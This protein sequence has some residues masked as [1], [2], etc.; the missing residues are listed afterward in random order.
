M[1][2]RT[3]ITIR[4]LPGR[5]LE[6]RYTHA[7]TPDG[8]ALALVAPPHPL[9]GGSIGNPVVRAIENAYAQSGIATLAFN[10]RGIGASTG[11]PSDDMA[12]ALAEYIAAAEALPQ[13]ALYALS[14]YSFGAIAA[15]Q[16]AVALGV[17]RVL[18]VAPPLFLL[19]SAPLEAFAGRLTIFVGEQDEYAPRDALQVLLA[20]TRAQVD[21]TYLPGVDHF[22]LGSGSLTLGQQLL[23]KVALTP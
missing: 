12:D 15:L 7:A 19:G 10:F 6:G 5:S 3:A 16:A 9:D 13:H 18:L 1:T 14:G 23:A 20:R 11:E 17:R 8:Q 2:A 22:F 21:L 4:T